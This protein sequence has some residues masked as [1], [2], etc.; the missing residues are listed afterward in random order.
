VKKLPLIPMKVRI[1]EIRS[2]YASAARQVIAALSSLEPDT[3]TAV[4]SGAV[5]SQVK[6]IIGEL[7]A[8]V[9]AW[10]P[11]AIRAAYEESAGVARMRLEMIGAKALPASR[12][13]LARHD[14]K[15]A[16]LTKTVMTD[17]WKANRTIERTARKYLAVVG[18]AAAGVAKLAQV[19]MFESTDAL[20]FIKRL[21]KKARPADVNVAT[22]ASGTV[23]RQIRDYL[24]KKL[25]GQ[26]FIIIKGRHCDVKF[27]AE[28]VARTRMREAQTEA[29]KELCKEFANDL[30]Q[31]SK[32]DNPCEECAKYEGEVYSISGD[33]NEY[34]QLPEEAEPPVHP[35]CE[36]NLNPT[37]ESVLAW[38]NA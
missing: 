3:Y 34:D 35:N 10:T 31:F 14:R 24:L 5:L 29:T 32:H 37:S 22:M 20:P 25:S 36:H 8:A 17:Y 26:E 7:D 30:V 27:Y 15:I 23:S 12:Y 4:K 11:G 9:Q 19:Q 18:Q 33:S 16:A 6:N 38:R 28:L 13:N 2:V 1:A 21:L